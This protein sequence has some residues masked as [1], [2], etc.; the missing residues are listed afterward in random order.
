[1]AE[2][3]K[4]TLTA[5]SSQF[6]AV[7]K[8]AESVVASYEEAKAS[9]QSANLAYEKEYLKA[10]QLEAAGQTKAADALRERLSLMEAAAKIQKNTG[11][12][13]FEALGMAS[14]RAKAE[15]QILAAKVSQSSAK[16]LPELALTPEYLNAIEKATFRKNELSKATER[17][18]RSGMAGSMGFL[19]FS[20]AVED[21]QYGIKGVLNNIP[22]MVLGFG[23]T[24]GL[25]GA[26]S[27]ASVAAV[28]LIPLIQKLTGSAQSDQLKKGAEAFAEAWKKSLDSIR[29]LRFEA[30]LASTITQETEKQNRSIQSNLIVQDGVIKGLERELSLRQKS[31]SLADELTSARSDL[32]TATGGDARSQTAGNRN[33]E[34]TRLRKDAATNAQII[35]S[36][37]FEARRL[38][39]AKANAEASYSAQIAAVNLQLDNERRK[40]ATNEARMADAK[41]RVEG[42]DT[43][44]STSL[45]IKRLE[46]AAIGYSETIKLIEAKRE[47]LKS[48]SEKASSTAKEEI[49]KIH[50]TIQARTDEN[51]SIADTIAQRKE[52]FAIQD[53]TTAAN[54]WNAWKE[55]V[56][57][58]TEKAASD[59]KDAKEAAEALNQAAEEAAKDEQ[60]RASAK[61]GIAAE[62]ATLQ[63]QLRGRKEMADTLNKELSIRKQAA[64][65]AEET[66]WSEEKALRLV[67]GRQKL[68]EQLS[69]GSRSNHHLNRLTSNL[70]DLTDRTGFHGAS[71]VA[72]QIERRQAA[73]RGSITIS[74]D[75]SAKYW[76]RQLDLQGKLV[77]YLAK[78]G[79][80]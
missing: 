12:G 39:E 49:D 64:A 34:I 54:A 72:S 35:A 6:E 57:S 76:E 23:G 70:V 13:E 45:E 31:R 24:M 63:L 11:I 56:A 9:K 28:N 68:Q 15:K 37:T 71:I 66:G 69:G 27:L 73:K 20:Q 5:D 53:A 41:A 19:A 17:A 62:I 32:L 29:Q 38:V 25:A 3:I 43:S 79:L 18:G 65:L 44:T 47:M 78:L 59:M 7:F 52:L 14:E 61:A 30:S 46:R 74:N 55:S 80:A 75:P 67:R 36:G 22:Q 48:T 21:A 2:T 42:G 8:R 58:S 33:E 1:M 77:S 4:T 26:I 50:Q 51:Q 60:R 40:L 10:L 16:Q